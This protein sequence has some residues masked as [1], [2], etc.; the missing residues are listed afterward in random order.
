MIKTNHFSSKWKM[1]LLLPKFYFRK[2]IWDLTFA[3]FRVKKVHLNLRLFSLLS[4]RKKLIIPIRFPWKRTVEQGKRKPQR[5]QHVGIPVCFSLLDH[6]S[7]FKCKWFR[8][9][10]SSFKFSI[11]DLLRE[12]R[13]NRWNLMI[14]SLIPEIMAKNVFFSY[15]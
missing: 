14:C 1:F 12:A 11:F 2:S 7:T 15:L 8:F 6:Q 3:R 10:W 4:H 9:I 5:N 13:K